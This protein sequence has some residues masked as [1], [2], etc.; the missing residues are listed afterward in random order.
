MRSATAQGTPA[1]FISPKSW[2][3]TYVRG[4]GSQDG[5]ATSSW[6]AC[7]TRRKGGRP[8]DTDAKKDRRVA[9]QVLERI[10][11]DLREN[12]VVLPNDEETHLT[13]SAGTCRWRPDD[14]VRGLVSRADVALYRAKAEG[15]SAIVHLD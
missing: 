9:K 2:T 8:S 11:E 10:T 6:S 1:S 13:F 4:T 12:P 3:A 7:G 14:D 5:E 15:G